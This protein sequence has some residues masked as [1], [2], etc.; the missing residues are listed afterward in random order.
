MYICTRIL[1]PILSSSASSGSQAAQAV[2]R[3]GGTRAGISTSQGNKQAGRGGLGRAALLSNNYV[4]SL[5]KKENGQS[6]NLFLGIYI[7]N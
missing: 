5:I 1:L 6:E 4:S 2:R 7:S 3:R